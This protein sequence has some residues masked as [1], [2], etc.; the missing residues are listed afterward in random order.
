CSSCSLGDRSGRE[1]LRVCAADASKHESPNAG[2]P[3]AAMAGALGV[4]L[5]GDA[6]YGGELE[7]R[8]RLGRALAP[9]DLAA[10]RTSRILMWIETALVLA[11]AIVLRLIVAWAGHA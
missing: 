9:L 5:G 6:F 7:R 3:E 1:S 11:I 2:Y 4:E 8:P 10:L